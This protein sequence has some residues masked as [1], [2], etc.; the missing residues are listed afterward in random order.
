M[1]ILQATHPPATMAAC[2]LLSAWVV[3]NQVSAVRTNRPDIKT[4][5]HMVD[6]ILIRIILIQLPPCHLRIKERLC[7]DRPLDKVAPE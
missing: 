1:A 5:H 3:I 2:Q 6:S 7:R 4:R